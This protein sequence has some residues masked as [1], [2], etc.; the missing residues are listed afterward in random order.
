VDVKNFANYI[1]TNNEIFNSIN[2][3][4]GDMNIK[5][6]Y[7]DKWGKIWLWFST[8]PYEVWNKEAG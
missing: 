5:R 2:D 8:R 1:Q 6:R 7:K 4:K 3:N